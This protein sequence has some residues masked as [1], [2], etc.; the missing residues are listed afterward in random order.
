MGDGAGCR[1]GKPL[2]HTA[3]SPSSALVQQ[4]N[5]VVVTWACSRYGLG[6]KL[7]A[8]LPFGADHALYRPISAGAGAQL[9]P[10]LFASA[11]IL[12]SRL[13]SRSRQVRV[14][15]SGGVRRKMS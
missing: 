2:E 5:L 3:R 4:L 10:T 1:Q 6:Q 12:V 11:M 14:A 8:N 9:G 7:A 13:E 15:P